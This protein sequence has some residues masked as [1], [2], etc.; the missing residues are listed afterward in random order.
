MRLFRH[1]TELPDDAR[2]A[3][4]AIGNFDGVHR[5]HRAVIGEAARLARAAGA[6][7]AAITFEPHPRSVF[8][9]DD[10]PFRLT[11]LR[12]KA[13]HMEELGVDLLF[14]IHFDSTFRHKSAADFVREVIVEG[15]GLRH[16]VVGYD[17]LF[18]HRRQGDAPFLEAQGRA[19]G[20]RVTAVGPVMDPQ[21]GV[22]SSTRVRNALLAGRSGEAARLL[23]HWWEVEGRVE[24]GDAR[25]RTIG[26]PTANL[27]LGEYLRPA[28][29]VYAVRAGIDTGSATVWHDGVANFGRR[30]TVDGIAERFEVHLFDFQGD[31]YGKHLRV[32]LIDYI[33]PEKKFASL[34]EL[35]AQ[36]IQ[37]AGAARAALAAR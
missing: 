8:R 24:H 18:G 5:G 23:G 4:A 34:G 11:P 36:I 13:R 29:G 20:F 10:P 1:Y 37:D 3:V 22:F 27:E 19:L 35:K 12:I 21:D 7:L 14:V 28:Y 31:L 26:Y 6:P 15:L 25:G 33:R 16:V 2:G 32:K 9:P 30:P 17:F